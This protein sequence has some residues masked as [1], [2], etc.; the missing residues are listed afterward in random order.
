MLSYEPVEAHRRWAAGELR[1]IDC[2]EPSE[3][4][5][6]RIEGVDL[7]PMSRFA[8]LV[9]D[10]PED[11]PVAVICRSGARSARVAEVMTADGRFGEVANIE[12]GIIAWAEAELP[13]EGDRPG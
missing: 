11:L 3:H 7:V 10:I 12:G 4:A 2:R 1:I 13:Y 9:D 5:S 6:S 8:D